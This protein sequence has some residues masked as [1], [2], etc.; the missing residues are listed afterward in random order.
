MQ[1]IDVMLGRR[2]YPIHIESGLLNNIP[3]LLGEVNGDRKWV[4]ISEPKLLDLH[5]N[6]LRL[7]LEGAGF[8]CDVITLEE[9][10]AS[11]NLSVYGSIIERL[12][13]LQCDRTSAILALGGGVVGDVSGFVAATFLRGIDYYQIPTTC[14]GMVDSAIGGKTGVNSPSGKNLVGA[15]Y[16][17][18]GVL[19][20]PELL[21]SL[22]RGEVQSGL[23]EV[24][25]YGAIRDKDFFH[26][27]SSWL[28]DTDAFPFEDAIAQCCTIKAEIISKDEREGSLRRIL[29]FGH[30]VG[31]A[32]EAQLGYGTIRH[33]EAVSYGMKCAGK[34]SC[35]M[36]FLSE[37]EFILLSST[38][39]K[40]PLPTLPEIDKT[41]LMKFIRVDKKWENLQLHF[42][43]LKQLGKAV[44]STAVTEDLIK[45][46]LEVFE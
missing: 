22:P 30:T 7:N 20:D 39:G 21:H 9:G 38:I 24:I 43:L 16:Q 14:L 12:I 31:H 8:A 32:L 35:E 27:V 3:S 6:T 44:I 28:D 18:K 19:I 46:S 5:G 41:A 36:G 34:I 17:P 13:E 29:N 23:G 26:K 25:K 10:E 42:V 15:V 45:N 11:K 2:S 40:L 4:I 37:E 33:G 1:T